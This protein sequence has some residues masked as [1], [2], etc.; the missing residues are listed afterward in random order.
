MLTASMKCLSCTGRDYSSFSRWVRSQLPAG[1]TCSRAGRI[2]Q[3]LPMEVPLLLV[4]YAYMPAKQVCMIT[5]F[6]THV[7][8]LADLSL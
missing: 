8:T 3:P 1:R 5:P 7:Q 6:Y 4:V 2:Q